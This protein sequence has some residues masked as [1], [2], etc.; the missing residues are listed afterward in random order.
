MVGWEYLASKQTMIMPLLLLVS[1][2]F[3]PPHLAS[4]KR[5][6]L[7]LIQQKEKRQKKKEK[8]NHLDIQCQSKYLKNCPKE[9]T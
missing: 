3:L 6:N 2:D 9:V 7:M 8:K 4:L 5:P 1:S